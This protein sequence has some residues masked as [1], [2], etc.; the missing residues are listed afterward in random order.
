MFINFLLFGPSIS[1]TS[2]QL[3]LYSKD[4][5]GNPKFNEFVRQLLSPQTRSPLQWESCL[6]FPSPISH[7]S[8]SEQQSSPPTQPCVPGYTE[9]LWRVDKETRFF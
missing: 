7:W 9:M 2:Q 8:S 5:G 4:S 1:L 3:S 6:Q